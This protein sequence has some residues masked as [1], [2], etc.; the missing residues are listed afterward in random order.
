MIKSTNYLRNS[1]VWQTKIGYRNGK[2]RLCTKF[3]V[4]FVQIFYRICEERWWEKLVPVSVLLSACQPHTRW[5][6]SSSPIIGWS[7]LVKR[8]SFL[9][10]H[11]C[12]IYFMQCPISLSHYL[13]QIIYTHL[14]F[15]GE[16]RLF[17]SRFRCDELTTFNVSRYS[18]HRESLNSDTTLGTSWTQAQSLTSQTLNKPLNRLPLISQMKQFK[19]FP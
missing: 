18:S 17:A 8:S 15:E 4:C 13:L 19:K 6:G 16:F 5:E 2:P 1:G 12:S 9:P 14:A 10:P 3:P 7:E 11:F